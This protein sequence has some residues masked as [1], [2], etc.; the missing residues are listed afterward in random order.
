M[1]QPLVLV[2]EDLHWVDPTSLELL[3]RVLALTDLVPLMVIAVFRPWRQEASWRIHELATRDYSHRYTPILL[4]PL[5]KDDSRQLLANLLHVEDLPEKVRGLILTKSEG[6][7][8]FVEEVIRSLLDS[9][10]I[11][12]ENSHWRATR[13]I[14]DIAVPD[15]LA[16]VINS[17]LDQLDES[18][19]SVLQ[20]GA[21]I[22]REFQFETLGNVYEDAQTV[23][24]ALVELQRRELVREKS[25]I[26][27]RTYIFKHSLTQEAAYDTLLL[28]RRREIHRRVAEFLVQIEPDHANE[29]ARH[30]LEARE[31]ARALPYL[32]DAGDSDLRAYSTS[33][34][35]GHFGKALEILGTTVDVPL[36][37][38]THEGLGSALTF[39]FDIAGAVENYHTMLHLAE[40][41]QDVP[42]QVSA[43][44]KLAFVTA[45]MRGE[46]P[47]AEKHLKEA[48]RLAH[49]CNDL[50]GLA[51]L[52]MT[53]C[54][55]YTTT[56]DFDG[57][58]AHQKESVQIGQA[59]DEDESRLFGMAHIANTMTF[60]TRFDE[61]WEKTN[62]AR[63]KAEELGNRKYIAD[64]LTF[65][66]PMYHLRNG[67]LDLAY[68]TAEEGV[69]I[70]AE[71]GA[72]DSEGGGAFFLGQIAWM[73]GEYEDAIECQRRALGAGR[74]SGL[75]YLQVGPLC[76]L[77]TI[78]QDISMELADKAMDF[79]SQAL[80]LMKT[81]LGE[82]MGA[83]N[84]GEIGFC[85]LAAGEV[86]QA[87]ELFQMGLTR[88]TATKYLA[89]PQLLIG[90]A[91]VEMM[92]GQCDEAA[93]LV[94]EAR[95]FVE[96]RSMKHFYALV[97]FADAQVNAA[98][99]RGD[100]AIE[101]FAL[102]EEQALQMQMRPLVWQARAGAAQ[103]L[104]FS[105]QASKAEVKLGEARD[106]VDEIG[107][108]FQDEDMRGMFLKNASRK[109]N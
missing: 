107:G 97:A 50:P 31:P 36:L 29:I 6:N 59:I 68:E 21:V 91:F 96:E 33:A 24:A 106:M 15:T 88:S 47:E 64:A 52:H 27:P 18:A 78:Y 40:E 23:E 105:G 63:D 55:I 43:I 20:T 54:Y 17:R 3:E 75:A 79:H 7:P 28:S 93:R 76:A 19:R 89:R 87:S 58:L 8:F 56:G 60:L 72:S 35:I 98:Q 74:D 45:I 37:R 102:A 46:F 49:S 11:V 99:G 108:L 100:E 65:P 82:A 22:G 41:H 69:S 51:E 86:E 30:F 39:S 80:E 81:P 90:S 10:L 25:H 2:F 61:A 73:K 9:A 42:M 1:E 101:S 94:G 5:D 92:K 26:P 103:L 77:G 70:G 32:V 16:G 83:S 62:E 14:E 84:W 57:A 12:R 44:N 109:L 4:E 53:Y 71:I 95:Q 48:E 38:R 13:E 85:A 67:N 66:M 34:A 104:S